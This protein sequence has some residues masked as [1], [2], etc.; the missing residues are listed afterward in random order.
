MR[1]SARPNS[2]I[3]Q[4]RAA[5]RTKVEWTGASEIGQDYIRVPNDSKPRTFGFD[6][7]KSSLNTSTPAAQEREANKALTSTS[8]QKCWSPGG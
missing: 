1:I 7:R 5:L 4:E 2:I 6:F 8:A 3:F